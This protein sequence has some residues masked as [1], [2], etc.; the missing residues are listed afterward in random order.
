[1]LDLEKAL[2]TCV[3]KEKHSEP[4]SC[5]KACAADDT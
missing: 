4:H 5:I 2:D 1:M 3:N